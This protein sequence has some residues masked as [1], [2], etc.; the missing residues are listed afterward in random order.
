MFTRIIFEIKLFE[1][2]IV[3]GY[4][5]DLCIMS[6]FLRDGNVRDLNGTVKIYLNDDETPALT[7]DN[8]SKL[9]LDS[10]FNSYRIYHSQIGVS[11]ETTKITVKYSDG[12]EA[13][14]SASSDFNFTYMTPDHVWVFTEIEVRDNVYSNDINPITIIFD[15]NPQSQEAVFE[16][17]Y[18]LY[19]NGEKIDKEFAIFYPKGEGAWDNERQIYDINFTV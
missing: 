1:K 8:I 4:G 14:V 13:D 15:G 12:N 19:L 3:I 5:H 10:E 16:S 2:S 7:I 11:P 6:I 18:V 17:K 9:E